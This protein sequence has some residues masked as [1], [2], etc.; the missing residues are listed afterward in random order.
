MNLTP[1]AISDLSFIKEFKSIPI[2]MAM[3]AAPITCMGKRLSI[4]VAA[5]AIASERAMPGN[6]LSDFLNNDF[7]TSSHVFII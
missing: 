4:N 1:G 2:N 6:V 7:I 3:T 5:A